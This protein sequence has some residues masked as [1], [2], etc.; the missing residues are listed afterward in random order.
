[1]RYLSA[2]AGVEIIRV[3]AYDADYGQNAVLTYSIVSGGGDTFSINENTGVISRKQ[4]A[5][6]DYAVMPRYRLTVCINVILV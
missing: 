4:G 6:I 1:M 3:T 5:V 2:T